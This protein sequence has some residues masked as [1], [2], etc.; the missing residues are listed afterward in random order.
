[1][2]RDAFGPKTPLTLVNFFGVYLCLKPLL[3]PGD[4]AKNGAIIEVIKTLRTQERRNRIP[5]NGWFPAK[6]YKS[7]SPVDCKCFFVIST[8]R[9]REREGE[10]ARALQG[11][12]ELFEMLD[13][14]GGGTLTQDEFLEGADGR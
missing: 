10:C 3:K 9:E 5:E 8:E 13:V 2:Q 1:M 4:G 14:D 11:M 7:F 12:E 6:L